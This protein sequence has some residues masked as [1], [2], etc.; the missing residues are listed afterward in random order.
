MT[1]A[2]PVTLNGSPVLRGNIAFPRWGLWWAD[3]QIGTRDKSQGIINGA[4]TIVANGVTLNG[5]IVAGSD[6]AGKAF[7]RIVGGAGGWQK[8]IPPKAYR[9]EIGIRLSTVVTDAA[10]ACGETL[11]PLTAA[12]QSTI[13]GKAWMRPGSIGGGEAARTLD[14]V[15]P[16]GW[17]VDELGVT[18][19]GVRAPST[20]GQVYTLLDK[21]PERKF[22]IIATDSFVGI[23][24]GVTIEGWEIAHVRHEITPD[25]VRSHV[26]GVVG[27]TASDRVH[28]VFARI[29]RQL[30]RPLWFHGLYRYRVTAVS[31]GFL[32]LQPV[33]S[34][35]GLPPLS[36]VA[37]QSGVPGG[38]GTPTLGSIAY[39]Q[40]ANGDPTDPVVVHYSGPGGAKFVPA[41]SGLD[42]LTEV[43]IGASAATVKVGA[44]ANVVAVGA[45]STTTTNI[46]GGGAQNART[47]DTVSVSFDGTALLA[48]C[49]DLVCAG[50]GAPP[51][52]SP[53]ANAFTLNGT[54]TGGSSKVFSG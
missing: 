27:T 52:V 17:Y 3:L 53:T 6:Y 20:L 22:A 8:Q 54:I 18:H 42:A 33:A 13:L 30:T 36:N 49:H 23:V 25:A 26:W 4:A 31:G 29:V 7:Y 40:F 24:P 16:E 44:T 43:D 34:T 47:G 37:M 50:S 14:A 1:A 15:A 5:T 51:T 9:G 21:R 19:I 41:I 10:A 39:V 48:L 11:A 32:D 46:A 45:A 12:Q 38:G 28:Q 2:P 35:F